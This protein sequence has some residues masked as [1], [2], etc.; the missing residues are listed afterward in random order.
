MRPL[1][2]SISPRTTSPEGPGDVGSSRRVSCSARS[3]LSEGSRSRSASTS[4]G[5]PRR[6]ALRTPLPTVTT[7]ITTSTSTTSSTTSILP[8]TF[9]SLYQDDATGIVRIDASTCQGSGVGTGF[10]LTPAL[11]ATAAH[12]VDGAVAIGLTANGKTTSGHVV[13]IDDTTDVALVQTSSPLSGHL[14]NLASELPA[15]GTSIGVIGFPEG[16]PISFSQGAVSG[17]D[18]TIDIEG[19]PRGGLIQTDAA[20]NPGNSGGPLLLLSGTVTG[21]AD[22]V[23]TGAEGLGYAIPSATAAPLLSSWETAPSPPPPP[24]CQSALGPSDPGPIQSHTPTAD[25]QAITAMLTTYFDS[26]D[27]GDYATAYAQLGAPEQRLRTEAQFALSEATSYA[28]DVSIEAI[29]QQ[30]PSSDLVDVMFTSL[31]SAS[32]GPNGDTCDIWTL[33]YTIDNINGTWL[34]DSAIGQG[35][36]THT[37]C[38]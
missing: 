35:G 4:G 7:V 18:R 20:L 28:Y 15:V 21:L 25:S 14:F 22:A 5:H 8:A 13:G 30:S 12:V 29:S 24:V 32:L 26:I 31:Q 27:T 10:L 1:V 34:I 17:L 9:A 38:G 37:S 33:E 16:G 6:S 2:V 11:L 23:N 36:S 19:Q 3:S